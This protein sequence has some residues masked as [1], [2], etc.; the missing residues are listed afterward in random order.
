MEKQ[1]TAGDFVLSP[2][3]QQCGVLDV[4]FDG[5]PEGDFEIMP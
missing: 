4:S 1:I 5:I 2:K 3:A